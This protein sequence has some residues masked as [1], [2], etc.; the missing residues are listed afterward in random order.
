[1]ECLIQCYAK[2][3]L[4]ARQ[5][6]QVNRAPQEPGEAGEISAKYIRDAGSSADRK[7]RQRLAGGKGRNEKRYLHKIENTT[8]S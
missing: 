7:V 8:A 1:M 3:R 5:F 2:F 4:A 6:A